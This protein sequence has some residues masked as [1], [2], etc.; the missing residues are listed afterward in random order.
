MQTTAPF[1]EADWT[2]VDAP[3][4][5]PYAKSKT[6]AERAARDFVREHAGALHY[7]SVNPGF[8]LGP[9]LSADIRTSAEIIELMLKGK[10]PG[11]PRVSFACVRQKI[12]PRL[13][14][15]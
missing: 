15:L 5:T 1:T 14:H 7:S 10:Y 6:L 11:A 12:R 2:I 4:V 13:R 9:L 3:G 8:V